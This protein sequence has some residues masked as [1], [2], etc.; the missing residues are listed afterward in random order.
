MFVC[1][2]CL[3]EK[4]Y[5]HSKEPTSFGLCEICGKKSDCY[6]EYIH[7]PY[8]HI[9]DKDYFNTYFCLSSHKFKV[10]DQV[11]YIGQDFRDLFDHEL[12]KP[13]IIEKI[14]KIN[15][16][17]NCYKLNYYEILFPEDSLELVRSNTINNY[18]DNPKY[19][20]ELI[21]LIDQ[22]RNVYEK[23]AC[24]DPKANLEEEIEEMGRRLKLVDP[25]ADIG[26]ML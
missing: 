11:R 14:V 9:N 24:N 2:N 3:N 6:D 21:E 13:L 4:E 23:Y 18:Q 15:C 26:D 8:N 12:P 7:E 17:L 19:S 20:K 5:P 10:G 16:N 22:V 1:K 25:S